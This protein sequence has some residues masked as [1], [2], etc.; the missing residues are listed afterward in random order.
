VATPNPTS[1]QVV[2]DS[3]YSWRAYAT[4]A[5]C[6]I[7]I[8]DIDED[9]RSRLV[10]IRELA[11]NNGPPATDDARY[12]VDHIGRDFDIDPTATLWV[13]HWGSFSHPQA[14]PTGKEVFL[15]ATF[16]RSKGGALGSPS[17]RVVTREDLEE[18]TDRSFR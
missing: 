4:V 2:A 13:F 3:T 10:V 11:E 14:R 17:W 8:Y 16:R 18:L 1:G 15:R 12:L 7:S 6:S 5:T 9:E